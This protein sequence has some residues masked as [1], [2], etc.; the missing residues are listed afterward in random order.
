LWA[1]Y[2][3]TLDQRIL[4]L[5]C[6]EGLLSCRSL[7]ATDR[8]LHEASV[9]IPHV[10]EHFD[11]PHVAASVAGRHFALLSPVDAMKRPV[12]IVTA[13]ES[14]RWTEKVYGN[15]GA[16]H[17]FQVASFDPEKELSAQYLSLLEGR[18]QPVVA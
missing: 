15:A 9:F 3:A 2:A 17:R 7:T 8:Y 6:H 5:V 10:L 13:R 1:L 12:D 4:A 11:L 18:R 16:G 14:Y